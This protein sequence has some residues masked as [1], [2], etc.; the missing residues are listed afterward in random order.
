MGFGLG[1]RDVVVRM[2]PEDV[3]HSP[4]AGFKGWEFGVWGSG[5]RA[6]FKCI[7]F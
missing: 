6:G 1:R 5:L 3:S 7:G 2:A 4:T